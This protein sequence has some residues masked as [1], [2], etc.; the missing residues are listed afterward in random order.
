MKRVLLTILICV[1]IVGFAHA[2]KVKEFCEYGTG[3]TYGLGTEG[4][5]WYQEWGSDGPWDWYKRSNRAI[6]GT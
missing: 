5:L 2:Q 6:D 3:F 1:C 4:G